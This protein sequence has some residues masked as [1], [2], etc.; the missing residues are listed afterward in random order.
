VV[1]ATLTEGA[2]GYRRFGVISREKAMATISL[3]DG[4]VPPL[5]PP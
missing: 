2:V 4:S 1:Q 3:T 5:V